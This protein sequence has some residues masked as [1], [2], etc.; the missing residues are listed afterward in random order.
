MTE[1]LFAA[2]PSETVRAW[3]GPPLTLECGKYL[4]LDLQYSCERDAAQ[5]S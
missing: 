4:C 1:N 5:I 2:I 3:N